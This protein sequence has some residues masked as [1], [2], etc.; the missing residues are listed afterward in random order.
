MATRY[1]LYES[2]DEKEKYGVRIVK[3]RIV[4]DISGSRAMVSNLV[5]AC[6][7]MHLDFEHFDDVLENYLEDFF[8]F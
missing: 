1:S 7:D 5:D 4:R 8:S 6:N 3:E 2:C